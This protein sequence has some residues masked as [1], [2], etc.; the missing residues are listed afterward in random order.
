ML[1]QQDVRRLLKSFAEL[2]ELRPGTTAELRLR[3][4]ASLGSL[5]NARAGCYVEI[6]ACQGRFEAIEPTLYG[7]SETQAAF[8][9]RFIADGDRLMGNPV[10]DHV[11]AAVA[12]S[13]PR[14]MLRQ[15]VMDTRSWYRND[16]VNEILKSTDVDAFVSIVHR[17]DGSGSFASLTFRRPWRDR[18][19]DERDRSLLEIF[20]A[21]GSKS[22]RIDRD[23]SS[24][25]PGDDR[26]TVRLSDR[27]RDVLRRLLAGASEKQ[28][29]YAF[30]RSAHT[31]HGHVKAIYRIFHVSSRSELLARFIRDETARG[32]FPKVG[33]LQTPSQGF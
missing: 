4:L 27:Q 29:A 2:H 28:I 31:I 12:K 23:E 14:A 20:F 1:R 22:L 30:G 13:E 18:C 7:F 10:A 26:R 24:S 16:Y 3:A 33:F 32:T 19:F 5:L 11:L 9:R 6:T 21:E 17:F 25:S 15:Q 8:W